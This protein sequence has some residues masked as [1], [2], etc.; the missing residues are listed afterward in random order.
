MFIIIFKCGCPY[1][2]SFYRALYDQIV[3]WLYSDSALAVQLN[4]C[5]LLLS[6]RECQLDSW[7]TFLM[8]DLFMICRLLESVNNT[9]SLIELL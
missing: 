8:F 3:R 2:F 7:M 9:V 6:E 1:F 4:V 5:F